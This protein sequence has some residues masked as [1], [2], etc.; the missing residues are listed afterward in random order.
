MPIHIIAFNM[1][2]PDDLTLLNLK[3]AVPTQM[4][5][6]YTS[7]KRA[8]RNNTMGSQRAIDTNTSRLKCQT[9]FQSFNKTAIHV[10]I[11]MQGDCYA[12]DIDRKT[13]VKC[14]ECGVFL[15]L[16]KERNCFYKHHQ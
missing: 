7:K 3:I 1:L 5:G 13:F 8:T 9:T 16:V 4:I 10:F 2:N 14:C 15:C 12:G 11:V 6:P